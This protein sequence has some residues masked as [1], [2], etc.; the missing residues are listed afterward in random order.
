MN[1]LEKD[2][3]HVLELVTID[4]NP[5]PSVKQKVME[6]PSRSKLWYKIGLPI[7]AVLSIIL[8]AN[9]GLILHLTQSNL[10]SRGPAPISFTYPINIVA[11]SCPVHPDQVLAIQ[12]KENNWSGKEIKLYYLDKT[13]ASDS[14]VF[15]QKVLPSNAKY[16]GSTVIEKGKWSFQWKAPNNLKPNGNNN[17]IVIA[18]SDE[19]TLSAVNLPTLL[20]D[21]LEV[22]PSTVKAGQKVELKGVGFPVGDI[23]VDLYKEENGFQTHLGSIHSYN[24]SFNFSFTPKINGSQITPGTYEV[25]I[26]FAM[27]GTA[28]WA[29]STYLTVK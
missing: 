22:N 25:T 27:P 19:G 29:V 1:N 9:T 2:I 24:G 3:Q 4:K 8:I 12:P 11:T 26:I 16:I 28:G 23:R 10:Q 5:S 18:K 21:K 6:Q 14:E 17:F 7:L 20:Y 15:F 13:D